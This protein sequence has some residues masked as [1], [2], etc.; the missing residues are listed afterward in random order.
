MTSKRLVFV[1]AF[2]AA[3]L[4]GVA[5]HAALARH[6][7]RGGRHRFT[8]ALNLSEEQ[9]EKMREI[10][11]SAMKESR[12]L[13]DEGADSIRAERL[14]ATREL[15]GKENLARYDEILARER[16]A[17]EELKTRRRE[18]LDRAVEETG[19]LLD[20]KQKA[21]YDELIAERRARHEARKRPLT[22][23]PEN[24]K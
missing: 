18:L 13:A 1:A 15:I 23:S 6:T 16:A 19:K 14:E 7:H 24:P 22:E 12:R 9:S 17:A 11:S 2:V 21:K 5:L 3:F 20:D 10:F 8:E 4:A